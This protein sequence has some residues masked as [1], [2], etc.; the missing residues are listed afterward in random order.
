MVNSDSN[1][2][3]WTNEA[4]EGDEVSIEADLRSWSRQERR[5]RFMINGKREKMVIVGV[6]ESIRFGVCLISHPLFFPLPYTCE[7]HS[8]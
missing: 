8:R 5:I 4:K 6:P 1:L 7:G 2:V 3:G